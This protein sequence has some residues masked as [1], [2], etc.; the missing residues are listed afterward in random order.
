[1]GICTP[2]HLCIECTLI[3][4]DYEFGENELF[5]TGVLNRSIVES[6]QNILVNRISATKTLNSLTM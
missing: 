3:E 1:M 4:D 6:D 2:E 5:T